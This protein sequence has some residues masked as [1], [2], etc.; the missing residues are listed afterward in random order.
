MSD[1]Q[2]NLLGALNAMT[3]RDRQ[4]MTDAVQEVI[5][6]KISRMGPV[7]RLVLRWLTPK[8]VA[9]LITIIFQVFQLTLAGYG[10]AAL[11]DSG[12]VDSDVLAVME[13]SEP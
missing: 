10:A 7:K 5:R 6:R 9:L 8:L 4:R 11:L 1:D 3:P 13:E 12:E 2:R